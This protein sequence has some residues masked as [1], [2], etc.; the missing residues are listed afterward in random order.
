MRLPK[1]S[2]AFL[3]WFCREDYIEEIEGDIVE[4]FKK[5]YERSPRL[6]YWNFAWRVATYLRPE[7]LKP[8][9]NYLSQSSFGICRNYFKVGLRSLMKDRTF[10]FINLAGFQL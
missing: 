4:I 8:M 10:A 3:R 1:K 6:S 9:K 7:F 5:E 2:I